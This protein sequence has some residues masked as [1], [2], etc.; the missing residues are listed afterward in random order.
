MCRHCL[1]VLPITHICRAF[2]NDIKKCASEML[3]PHFHIPDAT[4][5][6]KVHIT[7]TNM[8]SFILS[9]YSM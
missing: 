5:Q 4:K 1:R 6:V 2:E 8:Y 3:A 7:D 9:M